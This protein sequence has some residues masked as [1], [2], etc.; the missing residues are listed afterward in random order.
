MLKWLALGGTGTLTTFAVLHRCSRYLG[1]KLRIFEKKIIQVLRVLAVFRA[2]YRGILR[3]RAVFST[4]GTSGHAVF[5]GS[6]LW[7]LPVLQVF[8]GSVLRVLHVLVAL[9]PL[10]LQV[11]GVLRIC[12][13]YSGVWSIIRPFVHR[14]LDNFI[15]V[16]LQKLF[17]DGQLEYFEC[18]WYFGSIYGEYS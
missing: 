5:R 13:V 7:I 18:W 16:C 17:T 2:Y 11:F 8:Q 3:V 4:A 6:I 14:F 10:V 1:L 12:T 15:P 9:R